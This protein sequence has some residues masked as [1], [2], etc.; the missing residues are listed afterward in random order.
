MKI[1][2]YNPRPNPHLKP[3][4]I[5]LSLLCI[6]RYL[7]QKGYDIQII[8]GNL[9]EHHLELLKETARESTVLGVTSMTGY[10]IY[11]GLRASRIAKESNTNLKVVWGG[12][13]PSLLTHQVLKNPYIDIVIKGQG[14]S[15]FLEV[16]QCIDNRKGLEGIL[17][18]HWKEEGNILSNPDRPLEPLDGMPPMN[19][20]GFQIYPRI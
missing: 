8:S 16:V 17:G 9:F 3:V 13:H 14:E 19:T 4:D 18:V 11:D 15:A 2:L 1:L 20:T 5:P 7:D 6:S 10:Q 12:W